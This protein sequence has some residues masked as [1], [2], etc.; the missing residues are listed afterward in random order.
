MRLINAFLDYIFMIIRTVRLW[1]ERIVLPYI[2][3]SLLFLALPYR[4]CIGQSN[5]YT[6]NSTPFYRIVKS[7]LVRHYFY[8][9][10]LFIENRYIILPAFYCL[11]C[12][13]FITSAL[14]VRQRRPD[15]AHRKNGPTKICGTSENSF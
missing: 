14:Q 11:L 6:K 8:F 9:I 15:E 1:A 7:C 3:N 13:T 4:L 5:S 12:V 10:V 2:N